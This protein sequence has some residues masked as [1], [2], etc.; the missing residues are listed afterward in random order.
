VGRA[1][2]PPPPAEGERKKFMFWDTEKNQIDLRIRLQYDG[3]NQSNFF[4]AMIAGYLAKDVHIMAYVGE[5]KE[6]YVIHNKKKR[7]ETE[8]LLKEGRELE[9]DFALNENDIENIFD[10]LEKEHPEL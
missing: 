7:K 1:K 3:M 4:R 5:Y 9:Q 6:K 8:Q 2:Y 10:I